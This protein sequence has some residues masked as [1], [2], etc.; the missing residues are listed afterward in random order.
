IM[1]NNIITVLN[2]QLPD[3]TV[4]INQILQECSSREITIDY[5]A[6]NRHS[7]DV[8]PA[9]VPIAIY[10]NNE[11]IGNTVTNT[12]LESGGSEKGQITVTIPE[13]LSNNLTISMV[14]DD[15]GD[16]TGMITELNELNNST[17]Q[18]IQLLE[19]IITP[20]QAL[21]NCDEGFDTATFDLYL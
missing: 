16:G 6:Y 17:S 14:V 15:L 20:L 9:T 13:N 21:T 7:T 4:Q 19:V 10:A 18:E 5:T 12:Q 1:I 2:S 8:L 3:A 11:L